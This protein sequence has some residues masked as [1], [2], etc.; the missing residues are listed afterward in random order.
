MGFTWSSNQ[1]SPSETEVFHIIAVVNN[2]YG[3]VTTAYS[4]ESIVDQN[5]LDD[6]HFAGISACASFG[7]L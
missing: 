7:S 4:P 5:R 2:R 6:C 3:R 1:I